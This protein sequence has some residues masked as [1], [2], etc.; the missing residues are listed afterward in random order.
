MRLTG[1]GAATLVLA[2]VLLG[3]GYV[4]GYP[5]LVALGAG[6]TGA[7]VAA[8]IVA[9]ARPRVAVVRELRPERVHRGDPATVTLCVR[10]P[11]T[12]RQPGFTAVDRVGGDSVAITVGSLAADTDGEYSYAVPPLR[13]G[14][15]EVGPLTLNRADPLGLAHS[16]LTLGATST[17]WVYPKIHPVRVTAGGHPR[18]HHDG[19]ASTLR[20]SI[21]LR[22]VREYV[23]GDEV[24]HL[25]WKATARTG[26]LMIRD[27]VDPDQPRFTVLLDDRPGVTD[28]E[29]PVELAASLVVSAAIAGHRCRLVTPSGVDVVVPPG[30]A[31]VHRLLD[32]LCLVRQGTRA[33]SPLVPETLAGDGGGSLVAVSPAVS[34]VDVRSL[35]AVAPGH[36]DLTV[37]TLGDVAPSIPGAI[38][39]TAPTAAEAVR[40]WQSVIDR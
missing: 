28:F 26:R 22:D 20:G 3:T 7:I 11:G 31:S 16:V 36:T 39:L 17:L 35:A 29:E 24:R 25:H 10:N 5:V 33:E 12:R 30:A 6:A 1:R 15:H 18:H 8:L 34:A 27:Y 14:R 38:A 13:R 4:A 40:V 2:A 9:I 19:A 37:I 23:P 32:E 21:D